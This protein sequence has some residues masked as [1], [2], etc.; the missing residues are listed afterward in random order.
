VTFNPLDE[1]ALPIEKQIRNW[2][3]L[4]D[5][6]GDKREAYRRVPSSVLQ[7]T[8]KKMTE[9]ARTRSASCH[10]RRPE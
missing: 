10:G 1:R 9:W 5:T 7:P 6:Q 4:S 8:A 2:R 3:Q